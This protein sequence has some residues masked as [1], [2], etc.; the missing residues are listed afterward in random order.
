M[1]MCEQ[2]VQ[3]WLTPVLDER[4]FLDV[5]IVKE[6]IKHKDLNKGLEFHKVLV[7]D[8]TLADNPAHKPFFVPCSL[9]KWEQV[10]VGDRLKIV[11]IV[12]DPGIKITRI[13]GDENHQRTMRDRKKKS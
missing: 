3:F 12:E 4:N 5:V 8:E 11:H 9:A 6:K 13:E 10:N 2:I 1:K 7:Y